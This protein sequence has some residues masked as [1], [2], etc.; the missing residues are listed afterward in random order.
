MQVSSF[1]SKSPQDFLQAQV[2]LLKNLCGKSKE[3]E[4]LKQFGKEEESGRN[5][6][7]QFQEFLHSCHNKYCGPRRGLDEW[8]RR[9][10]QEI[11]P[12]K[13]AQLIFEKVQ[14]QFNGGMTATSTNGAGAI[15]HPQTK[16]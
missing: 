1:T 10:V 8:N 5:Q 2:R 3:I 15:G 6:S 12:Q 16:N 14:K 7:T 13:Y 11:N 4:Y 9:E